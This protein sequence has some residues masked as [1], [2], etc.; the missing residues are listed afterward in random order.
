M[1]ADMNEVFNYQG[2]P[3]SGSHDSTLPDPFVSYATTAYPRNMENVLRLCEYMWLHAGDFKMALQRISRYFITK[4]EFDGKVS[5]KEKKRWEEFLNDKLKII[6]V[7]ST[8]ADDFLCFHGDVTTTTRDGVFKLRDLAGRTVDVLSRDGVYRPATFKQFGRQSLMEIEFS[9]G[10][11]LL[12][13][14][15]HQWEVK[16]HAGK[17][18]TLPTMRLLP[19]HHIPRTVAPRPEQNEE[20]YEG[21]RHGFTFG[22]GTL[23]NEGKQAVALFYGKKDKAVLKYFEGHGC[24]PTY[25]PERDYIRVNG[26][27]AYYKQLPENWRSASYWYG[28]VCGF[29]A[30]D[31]SVDTYGC[32]ILTQKSKATLEAIAA[33][34]PR[35][36]MVAGPIRGHE[37]TADFTRIN[38]KTAVYTSVM[39]YV[40][41]L[42]QY[43]QPQ[44]FLAEAHRAKFDKH[45]KKTNYGQFVAVKEV[46][47]TGIVDDVFCCVEPET[48]MFVVDNGILTS[49]CYGNSFTTVYLPFNRVL[50]CSKCSLTRAMETVKDFQFDL[51]KLEFKVECPACK[52]STTHTHKDL[53]SMDESGINII[54]WNHHEI[55]LIHDFM[56][57]STEFIWIIS[58]DLR[59]HIRRGRTFWI[60]KM[61]WEVVKAVRDNA[62]FK[63]GNQVLFHMK[64]DTIAGVRNRGWGI[65]RL[66]AL[67]KDVYYLQILKRFNEA[68]A[69]DYIM[70][71][72]MITPAKATGADPLMQYDLSDFNAQ[73]QSMIR[74]HRKDPAGYHVLP[75]PVQYQTMSGE[76]A[77]MSPF[78]L[79]KQGSMDLMNATGVPIDLFQ[80]SMQLNCAPTA[81]RLFQATWP[82]LVSALNSWLQWFV[83][84]ISEVFGWEHVKVR[85]QPVTYA[86]DL[87]RKGMLINLAA[88]QQVSK[89]TAFASMGVDPKEEQRRMLEETRMQNDTQKEFEQDEAQKAELQQLSETGAAGAGQQSPMAMDPGQA[90]VQ[91]MGGQPGL[92]M[93]GQGPGPVTPGEVMSQADQLAQQLMAMP[94]GA[95]K[96]QLINLKRTNPMLHGVVKQK[97]VDMTQQAASMGVAQ[98]RQQAQGA[99]AVQ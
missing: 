63:F 4:V 78:Q 2:R 68:F 61:P 29:L 81:L 44:D 69:L 62:H 35:I 28:F 21:V 70:P 15:E 26:L 9:D 93:P 42:K 75:F 54:R 36:G 48:H 3:S 71:F 8:I 27:P 12:A 40:T 73:M 82:H 87:D 19:G 58:P 22:D 30:A 88:S 55:Q 65:P 98:M 89:Q 32:A 90:G 34:L 47:E 66:L 72:R 24:P 64:E 39:H 84:K 83:D 17:L 10:R 59:E 91:P 20:F 92:Q 25:Y 50:I 37:R 6:T 99:P 86:D 97:M 5:D 67:F 38:G 96:G 80:G 60:R 79:I 76:G 57:G 1:N 7:L 51:Q 33:Q 52:T 77:Q 11:T 16:N 85:L 53:R 94:E 43:M 14:P 95:R 46:R 31:G 45:N 74:E 18:V 49:N 23:Y 13:T 41:L 56:S